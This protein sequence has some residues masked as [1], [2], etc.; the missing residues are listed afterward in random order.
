MIKKNLIENLDPATRQWVRSL[1]KIYAFQSHH[2]K[3]LI[4]AAQAWD[5]S[6]SA[7][8]EIEVAGQFITDETGNVKL[9]PGVKLCNEGRV[10]FARLIRELNLDSTP[11]ES[12]PPR[13]GG[14]S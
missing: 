10:I 8:K 9:H 4:L 12:R 11:E 5:D 3:L 2:E 1:E 7:R 13:I 6:Q 14:K